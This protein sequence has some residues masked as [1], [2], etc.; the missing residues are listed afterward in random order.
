MN[1][2]YRIM[3][4]VLLLVVTDPRLMHAPLQVFLQSLCVACFNT[5]ANSETVTFAD[6]H[7]FYFGLT[8]SSFKNLDQSFRLTIDGWLINCG[9]AMHYSITQAEI[10]EF[11]WDELW[12]LSDIIISGGP[13]FLKISRSTS[14]VA[15]AEVDFFS[16]ISGNL[17]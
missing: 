9:R 7:L 10:F 3:K 6:L 2:K 4:F 11:L 16:M 17:L 12:P 5:R 14:T 13:C 1:L 15:T 8:E